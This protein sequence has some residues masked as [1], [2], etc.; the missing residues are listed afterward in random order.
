M[1]SL[2]LLLLLAS[3]LRA[4]SASTFYREARQAEKQGNDIQA[5]ALA[6][7]A[8]TLDPKNSKYRQQADRLRTRAAQIPPALGQPQ[9][10]LGV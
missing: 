4:Q 5:F 1:R 3:T 9:D 8:A 10:P 6:V 2:V 7:R